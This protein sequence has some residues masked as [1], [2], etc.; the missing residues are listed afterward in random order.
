MILKIQNEE[1]P[2]IE[3]QCYVNEFAYNTKHK[4]FEVYAGTHFLTDEG[5]FQPVNIGLSET[6]AITFSSE[7]EAERFC[8]WIVATDREAEEK[9][10]NMLN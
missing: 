2:G 1:K 4:Q 7:S 6:P 8:A 3:K 10:K 5:R 9:I